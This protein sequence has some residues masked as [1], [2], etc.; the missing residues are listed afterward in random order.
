MNDPYSILGVSRTASDEEVKKAYRELARK[1][2]PDNYVN[3]PLAD[4][5]QE[6]MKQI[7]EAYDQIN[8]ERAGGS[9]TQS[10]SW[11]GNWNS[12]SH[13]AG[14]YADAR[15]AINAGDLNRA[16]MILGS[17][18]Q[19]GAEWHFLMGSLA[20]RRG[21][22]DE[23]RRHFSTAMQMEPGNPEYRQAFSYMQSAAAQPFGAR[24][25]RT[26][27]PCDTCGNLLVLDCCCEMMGG[28]CVPCC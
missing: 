22:M 16:E 13:S 28:D 9:A 23:A 27:D 4:L 8:R 25:M 20:Y 18:T 19:R 2:H 17:I 12:G 1:Y 6:K 24:S 3:N 11:Q 15:S 5:A 10:Q 14:P 26:A 21:W 7:N